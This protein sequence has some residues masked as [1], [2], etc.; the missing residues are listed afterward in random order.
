VWAC[1]TFF[2]AADTLKNLLEA[3]TGAAEAA[4]GLAE[5]MGMDLLCTSQPNHQQ[6]DN[7]QAQTGWDKMFSQ[8]ALAVLS[9]NIPL[10]SQLLQ[11]MNDTH[12]S[13]AEA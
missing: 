4:K 2:C 11:L 6:R 9:R 3:L 5:S 7:A 1:L 8:T 13:L 10:G 12:A